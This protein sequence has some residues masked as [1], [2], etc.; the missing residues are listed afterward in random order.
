MAH[1]HW[2]ILYNSTARV[3]A[4]VVTVTK[5]EPLYNCHPLLQSHCQSLPGHLL[6][7]NSSD[8]W[9]GLSNL[10]FHFHRLIQLAFVHG[11]EIL[12]ENRKNRNFRSVCEKC[13]VSKP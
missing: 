7:I 11:C 2:N 10:T 6:S 5:L 9:L 8:M 3:C 13:D 1:E 4:S 12:T